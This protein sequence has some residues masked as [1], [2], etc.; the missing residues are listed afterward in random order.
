MSLSATNRRCYRSF[1]L[2]ERHR[3][4]PSQAML[5]Y[6]AMVGLKDSS[7]ALLLPSAYDY[8]QPHPGWDLLPPLPRHHGRHHQ[9]R[10]TRTHLP[11]H[12]PP[13]RLASRRRRRLPPPKRRNLYVKIAKGKAAAGIAFLKDAYSKFDP[14][15]TADFHF[16]D[17][18]FN[19]QYSSERK[20]EKLSLGF[21]ILAFIIA[22]M[23][24]LGL[25]IFITVQRRKEIG[26]RKVLGATVM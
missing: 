2:Q 17:E 18:N 6:R 8:G 15:N 11:R 13:P 7:N 9:N 14:N 1:M 20:E 19:R 10:R 21:T 24:L 16:L 4:R 5:Q 26:V 23:G 22:C 12:R 3:R 25:V